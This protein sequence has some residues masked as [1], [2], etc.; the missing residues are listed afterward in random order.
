MQLFLT[1][2]GCHTHSHQLLLW[3]FARKLPERCLKSCQKAVR[4]LL[5]N[6]QR[7]GI[8]LQE[9]CQKVARNFPE[10]WGDFFF[11][12]TELDTYIVNLFVTKLGG[13]AVDKI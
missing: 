13:G 6:C 8:K 5:D 7:V 9:S 12:G 11:K 10:S 3:S 2:F 1:D 4:K